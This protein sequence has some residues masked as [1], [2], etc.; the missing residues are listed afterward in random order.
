MKEGALAIGM[1]IN[2]TPSATHAEVLE[3]FRVAATYHASV[4]VHLRFLGSREPDTGLSALEEVIAA[5]ATTAAPLHVVHITSMGLRD[6][7]Q[8]MAL[9]RA[10]QNR[11]IDVTTE[12]Y[13][14]PAASTSLESALFDPGWQK[15]M[16]ISYA[17]LQWVKTGERLTAQTFA[18]Y[19]QE[20]GDVIVFMIPETIVRTAI[21]DPQVMIASD[22]MPFTGSKVHPRGQGT[23]SRVLGPYV[24]EERALDLMTALRKM[25]L[26][27]ARR[28]ERRAPLFKGK[29]RLRVQADADITIFDPARIVD[30]ATFDEPLQYSDG[31]QFVLV[32][33]VPV[34]SQGQLVENVFP[35]RATRAPVF[36]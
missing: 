8:L 15:R 5:A 1:A 21:A 9:I 13:P 14:Y 4:H 31:I 12:C 17:E 32:G 29:G 33:G 2:Y 26:E 16:G 28:L 27:P 20:G 25:T 35:G 7:P 10:A 18:R 22:G 23:F 11:G 6:T 3:V 19:R 34:V 30:R 36:Q 24:R